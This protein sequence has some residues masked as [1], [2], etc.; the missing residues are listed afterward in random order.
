MLRLLRDKRWICTTFFPFS[1]STDDDSNDKFKI[2]NVWNYW[3]SFTSLTNYNISKVENFWSKYEKYFYDERGYPTK[4][5][6]SV[7]SATFV[8]FLTGFALGG[9]YNIKDVPQKH[10]DENQVTLYKNKFVMQRELQRRVE[11][12]TIKGGF[13]FGIKVG[14]FCFFFSSISVFLYVYR[15]YKFDILNPMI[16]GAVTGFLFKMNMGIKGSISGT[17]IG[18]ILGTI[19]GC[20]TQFLLFITGTQIGDTYKVMADIMNMRRDAIKEN[21]KKMNSEEKSQMQIVYEKNYKMRE[22]IE[23]E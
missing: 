19:Y 18:T 3:K 4:E 11:F 21:V 6:Q 14:L 17:V 13:P 2:T 15:N 20:I 5:V 1:S 7:A 10:K 23:S 8:G 22:M 16:G 9:I 12:A